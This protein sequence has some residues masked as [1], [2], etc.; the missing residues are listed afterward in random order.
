MLG[1]NAVRSILRALLV[2]ACWTVVSL[3]VAGTAAAQV[4]CADFRDG[5]YESKGATPIVYCSGTTCWTG[6]TTIYF[7]GAYSMFN[8]IDRSAPDEDIYR[9]YYRVRAKDPFEVPLA[10]N[11]QL[12]PTFSS[13]TPGLAFVWCPY[14]ES[15]QTGFQQ[16]QF[17]YL[18]YPNGYRGTSPSLATSL[19]YTCEDPAICKANLS[20]ALRLGVNNATATVISRSSAF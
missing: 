14:P 17:S 4:G 13:T 6:N 16:W 1:L 3:S 12:Y 5:F 7:D 8:W 20:Y 18:D 15:G 19:V 11:S 9:M 2:S 10:G